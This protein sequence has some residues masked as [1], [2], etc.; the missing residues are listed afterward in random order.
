MI[1]VLSRC[2]DRNGGT[3]LERS[4]PPRAGAG[5]SARNNEDQARQ[6][7]EPL[8][9]AP[10]CRRR[11]AR[12]RGHHAGR[13]CR[14]RFRPAVER[15]DR[16]RANRLRHALLRPARSAARSRQKGHDARR[17]PCRM[18]RIVRQGRHQQRRGPQGPIGRNSGAGVQPACLPVG[19][20]GAGWARSGQRH[21]LG[22][23]HGTRS[24]S[25]CSS[26]ARSTPF[27]ASRPSR[28]ACGR[29]AS[30]M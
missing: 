2:R 21:Q 24:R 9:H 18:L 14:H 17:R 23:E 26:T 5:S 27:S 1:F 22:D 30:A 29:K 11:T 10:V 8:R 4:T 25:N 6:E 7:S 3:D 13:L 19:D 20:G 12:G 15:G 16:V 28:S